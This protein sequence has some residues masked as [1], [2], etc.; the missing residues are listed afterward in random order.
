MQKYLTFLQHNNQ[1]QHYANELIN[2][3]GNEAAQSRAPSFVN[4][5]HKL[6]LDDKFNQSQY[7]FIV[8]THLNPLIKSIQEKNILNLD[9]R[10]P[11]VKDALY[12]MSVQHQGASKIVNNTLQ[13]LKE[14]Y[15]NNSNNID[16]ASMLKALYKSRSNYVLSLPESQYKGDGKITKQEKLNIVNKR[17]PAELQN[18]LNYLK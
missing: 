7:N 9:N 6:S 4:T 10:H 15:G 13:L 8:N 16:D 18:A 1:Y 2:A 5:W 12:S 3:G 17:Y 11:V 14:E